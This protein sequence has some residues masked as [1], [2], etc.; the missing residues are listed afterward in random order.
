[1]VDL[2]ATTLSVETAKLAVKHRLPV[3]FTFR[4]DVEVGGLVAYGPSRLAHY[5]E[6]ATLVD[7]ILRGARPADLPVEQSTQFEVI[8]NLKTARALSRTI[9]P[10]LLL[11]AHQVIE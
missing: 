10:S 1:L 3:M 5:R 2:T 7:K 11:R 4:E 6:V 8:I 9:P